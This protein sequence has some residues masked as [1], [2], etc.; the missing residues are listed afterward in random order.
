MK[1]DMI[2][3]PSSDGQNLV[4]SATWVNTGIWSLATGF[5]QDTHPVRLEHLYTD[6]GVFM[7]SGM[8]MVRDASDV[9]LSR[10]RP[11]VESVV[12]NPAESGRT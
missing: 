4:T 10:L 7:L 9:G 11:L 1:T 6:S 2:L 8:W 3:L 12:L 5:V